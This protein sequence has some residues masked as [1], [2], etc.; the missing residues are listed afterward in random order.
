MMTKN[1]KRKGYIYE[2]T[3]FTEALK[4]GLEVF[5]PLGDHLPV[6]CIL[7]NSAGKNFNVQIKGSEKS[8]KGERKNGCKRYRFSTTTGRVVKQ[9]L[10]CTKVD[11]VAI[12]CA[13]INTW[14]LNPM[15]GSRWSINSCGLP[16][17]PRVQ[18]KTRKI[19]GS[20]GLI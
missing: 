6:D 12:F 4:N 11:I 3:F 2:Q 8:S 17:Q 20:V 15:Y 5:I 1:T 10:D 13:D 14:Y 19:S 9:P 18:S 16:G 7:V